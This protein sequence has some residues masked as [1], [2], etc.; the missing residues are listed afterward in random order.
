MPLR[1]IQFYYRTY[2]SARP[3]VGSSKPP[4]QAAVAAV[5][6]KALFPGVNAWANGSPVSGGA[7]GIAENIV[8]AKGGKPAPARPAPRHVALEQAVAAK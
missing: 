8:A 6:A 5:T 7:S 1:G 3:T 2:G 4:P